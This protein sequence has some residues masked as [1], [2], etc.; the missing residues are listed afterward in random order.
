MTYLTLN[1]ID[2]SAYVNDLKVTNS[3]RY[4][5]LT[6]AAGNTVVDYQNNKRILEVGIIPVDQEVMARLQEV[7]NS[8][9]VTVSFR[10]PQTNAIEENLNCIIPTNSVAYY[11]IRHDKVTYDAFVFNIQ[12]L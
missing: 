6:N 3:H 8:F 1:G 12:E 2:F 11:T 10:N 9:N 5:A 4:S 7:M